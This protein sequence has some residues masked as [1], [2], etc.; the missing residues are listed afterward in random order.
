MKHKGDREGVVNNPLHGLE[1]LI[2][3]NFVSAKEFAQYLT[4]INS[5][6]FK[7]IDLDELVHMNWKDNNSSTLGKI[8]LNFNL[9]AM[10]VAQKIL[11]ADKMSNRCNT[12]HFFIGAANVHIN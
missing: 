12:L 8:T 2:K 1:L 4:Q 6:H 11:E 5:T 10:W 7:E 9:V 3:T